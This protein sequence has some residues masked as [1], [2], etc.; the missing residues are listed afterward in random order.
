MRPPPKE[1]PQPEPV[2]VFTG[3]RDNDHIQIQL[4]GTLIRLGAALLEPLVELVL[5]RAHSETGYLQLE[6]VT[7]YRL[8]R[9]LDEVLGPGT[10]KSLIETGLAQEYRLTIPRAELAAKV[11]VAA[12]FAEL[13]TLKVISKQ[14]LTELLRV[15]TCL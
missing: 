8:R 9:A 12:S 14:Q 10:G 2:I 5:E 6:P 7:V 4:H 11:A 1:S 15:C 3:D 13:E